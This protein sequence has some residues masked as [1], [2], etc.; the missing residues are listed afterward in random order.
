MESLQTEQVPRLQ[1]TAVL[2]NVVKHKTIVVQN[3]R[4]VIPSL[5]MGAASPLTRRAPAR[6]RDVELVV[7]ML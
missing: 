7:T 3:I 5:E 4:S 1:D 6:V 2:A